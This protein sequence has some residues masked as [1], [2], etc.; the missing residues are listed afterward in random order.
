ME[1]AWG[2]I[3]KFLADEDLKNSQTSGILEFCSPLWP[4]VW[5][6]NEEFFF[7]NRQQPVTAL[8]LLSPSPGLSTINYFRDLKCLQVCG[9]Q[10]G[11]LWGVVENCKFLQILR[12]T[13]AH[14][15]S[16]GGVS[17]CLIDAEV[18]T[19]V[20]MSLDDFARPEIPNSLASSFDDFRSLTPPS[21]KTPHSPI[22]A[23]SRI[24]D[25]DNFP[26]RLLD[27]GNVTA[28]RSLIGFIGKFKSLCWLRLCCSAVSASEHQ[29]SYGGDLLEKIPGPSRWYAGDLISLHVSIE[30]GPPSVWG[31]NV[32]IS[33]VTCDFVC[34]LL[35]SADGLKKVKHM[36]LPCLTDSWSGKIAE[37]L[38]SLKSLTVI[39]WRPEEKP[40]KISSLISAN[41]MSLRSLILHVTGESRLNF[42]FLLWAIAKCPRGLPELRRFEVAVVMADNGTMCVPNI[43]T[44]WT[45]YFR[46]KYKKNRYFRRGWFSVVMMEDDP[47]IDQIPSSP[48]ELFALECL[49][50]G[51]LAYVGGA[52]EDE[53]EVGKSL[54]RFTGGVLPPSYEDEWAKLPEPR[55]LD[56][57]DIYDFKYTSNLGVNT[58]KIWTKINV[59]SF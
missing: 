57:V 54:E 29:E 49:P 34:E 17:C 19:P 40:E 33:D 1:S 25:K 8:R 56:Y 14:G 26:L 15:G 5:G 53:Q 23:Q 48:A 51:G 6:G 7:R 24:P 52:G 42:D 28:D 59:S 18:D 55:R 36:T 9:G 39:D 21:P 38:N 46:C 27:L 3:S 43:G 30:A 50:E 11:L 4:E 31:G 58:Q 2:I 45:L 10:L 13:L 20:R 12:F 32:G 44:E 16:V 35:S 22:L 47:F 37:R 41:W